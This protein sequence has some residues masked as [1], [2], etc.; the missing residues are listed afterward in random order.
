MDYGTNNERPFSHSKGSVCSDM[1]SCPSYLNEKCKLQNNIYDIIS[2][3]I[4]QI[5]YNIKGNV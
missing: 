4:K 3:T 5:L 1:E 2:D